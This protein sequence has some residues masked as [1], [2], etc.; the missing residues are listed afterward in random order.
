MEYLKRYLDVLLAVREVF[1]CVTFLEVDAV[2]L[3]DTNVYA[4][5]KDSNFALSSVP[6]QDLTVELWVC[7]KLGKFPDFLNY[8]MTGTKAPLRDLAN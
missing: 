2:Q 6:N 8:A 7:F 3:E 1:Q 5:V 4:F